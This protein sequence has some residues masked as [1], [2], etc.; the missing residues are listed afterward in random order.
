MRDNDKRQFNKGRPKV[1]ARFTIPKHVFLD[2]DTADKLAQIA[3]ESDLSESAT[4][5]RL[6]QRWFDGDAQD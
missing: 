4:I 1:G 6:I 3:K 2:K 5:R